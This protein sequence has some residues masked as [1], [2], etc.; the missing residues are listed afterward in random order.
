MKPQTISIVRSDDSRT[1]IWQIALNKHILGFR[2]GAWTY[3]NSD[4][5]IAQITA[6]S[7]IVDDVD[8][9]VGA[10]TQQLKQHISACQTAFDAY[11]E[12]KQKLESPKWPQPRA[13]SYRN[14]EV[15]RLT[16]ETLASANQLGAAL[17]ACHDYDDER[18]RL[19]KLLK[20]RIGV[21]EESL[22]QPG[23]TDRRRATLA[24]KQAGAEQFVE[25]L[26]T[27]KVSL[28]W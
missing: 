25:Q 19:I 10:I 23:I 5:K 24:T 2:S 4:P 27:A 20:N 26:R 6:G 22:S 21:L 1:A 28:P 11:L 7:I 12:L 17:E 18:A 15:D 16:N 13:S 8:A 9:Q 14:S 3:S